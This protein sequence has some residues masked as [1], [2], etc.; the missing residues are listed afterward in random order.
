MED[1]KYPAYLMGV[2]VLY[3]VILVLALTIIP[4]A[5]YILENV[6]LVLIMFAPLIIFLIYFI[7]RPAFS[8]RILRYLFVFCS[9]ISLMILFILIW[10]FF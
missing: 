1:E 10:M 7:E 3:M 2:A 8:K 6:L 4:A 5:F 9:A